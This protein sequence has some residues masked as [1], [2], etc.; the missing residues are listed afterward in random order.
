VIPTWNE[1]QALPETVAKAKQISEIL[2]IIVADG[3]SADGT[4]EL[5]HSLGCKVVHAPRGRG[6]QLRLG[7][8]SARGS[9]LVLL[10]ADTWLPP[11]AWEALL[12]CLRDPL[13]V[14]GGFWKTFRE[15]SWLLSGSRLRCAIRLLCF[16]R[17][18]GDQVIF[19]RREA[20]ERIGGIPAI[21]LMEEF[22]LCRQLRT[23]GRL[24]L[25]SATVTTSA[26]RFAKLGIGRTYL[27]MW[28]VTL[29]YYLGSSPHE[30]RELYERD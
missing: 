20:L 30:L 5:A 15:K 11:E 7:A 23:V 26:R 3:G 2:E 29:R 22:E 12:N 14:G 24:A 13:V 17:I 6:H 25:A 16:R 10:H 27:R 21:P 9:V 1:A 19:V 8:A 18:M 4:P 28:H